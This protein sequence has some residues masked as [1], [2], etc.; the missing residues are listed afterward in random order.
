MQKK[1]KTI[2]I[3]FGD[4]AYYDE[5]FHNSNKGS[6]SHYQ[7]I[8]K[9][10]SFYLSAICD[11]KNKI[12]NDLKKKNIKFYSDYKN[13]LKQEK[14]DLIIISTPDKLH[15]RVLLEA[16]KYYPKMVF[17]EKPMCLTL[18]EIKKINLI[19]KKKKILLQ[20]NY[21]RRFLK[22]Y[23]K[24]KKDIENKILGKM[25]IVQ[26]YYS[27]GLI[28]NGSHAIDLALWFFG[29]P[30]KIFAYNSYKSLSYKN[31]FCSSI[32]LNYN[33]KFNVEIIGIDI[34]GLG[35]IEMNFIGTKKKYF[36]NSKNEI[37]IYELTNL[38][39]NKKKFFFKRKSKIKIKTG[40][41][42]QYALKNFKKAYNERAKLLSSCNNSINIFRVIKN[43][44][45]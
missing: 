42:L 37:I 22:E 31:D 15:Y 16:S 20:V 13:I 39:N 11:K 27:K 28:H 45:N 6:I 36:I 1:Y 34:K 19:Y 33:K 14:A 40:E 7:T 43:C 8:L 4:I 30:K 17:C 2:I 10:K 24:I 3:G 44:Q 18:D 26:M 32:I 21:S 38:N 25:Q 12:E 23:Q 35:H 41:A 9:S 5:F 29:F